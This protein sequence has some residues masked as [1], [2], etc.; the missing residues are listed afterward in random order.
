[1]VWRLD[2]PVMSTRHN[3]QVIA[4]C[5]RSQIRMQAVAELLLL[6]SDL[7]PVTTERLAVFGGCLAKCQDSILTRSKGLMVFANKVKEQLLSRLPDWNSISHFIMEICELVIG[8]IECSTHAAYLMVMTKPQCVPAIPGAVDRYRVCRATVEIEICCKELQTTPLEDM[9]PH[10]LVRA[11][12][13]MNRYLTGFTDSCKAAADQIHNQNDRDQFK[14]CIKSFT[15]SA[16]CLMAAVKSFN[17]KP[18]ETHHQRC[19]NFC[20]PVI[21]STRSAAKFATE[22]QFIGRGARLTAEGKETKK[23]VFGEF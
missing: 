19:I 13:D 20:E 14:L 16:S 6:S 23:A 18:S 17:V 10:F 1:M 8:L 3:R 5:K 9:I 2:H 21:S 7:M 4:V 15:S 12:S 22:P 11:C